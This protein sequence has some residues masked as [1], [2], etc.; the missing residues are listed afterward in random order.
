M[1]RCKPSPAVRRTPTR[2]RPAE[3]EPCRAAESVSQASDP[4]NFFQRILHRKGKYDILSLVHFCVVMMAPFCSAIHNSSLGTAIR[5]SLVRHVDLI[6]HAVGGSAM[7][8]FP[9]PCRYTDS[10]YRRCRRRRHIKWIIC[11]LSKNPL[12]THRHA[13]MRMTAVGRSMWRGNEAKQV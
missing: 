4:L 12:W 13:N 7:L 9:S 1:N 6:S 5:T 2:G 3:P 11:W 10:C 8:I